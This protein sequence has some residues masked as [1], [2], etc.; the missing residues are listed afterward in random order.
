MIPDR[1]PVVNGYPVIQSYGYSSAD[2]GYWSTSVFDGRSYVSVNSIY[3]E[4]E[5]LTQLFE[6][7]TEI[8]YWLPPSKQS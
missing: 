6:T 8:P 4:G 1:L 7:L 3:L 5:S 2:T